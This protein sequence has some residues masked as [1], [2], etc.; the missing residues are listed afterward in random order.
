MTL[1][2][3]PVLSQKNVEKI[4]GLIADNNIDAIVEYG[5]GNSTIYFLNKYKDKHIKFISV[6]NTKPWFYKNIKPSVPDLRAGTY[7]SRVS[8]GSHVITQNSMPHTMS[9]IHRLRG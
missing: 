8:I 1:P 9:P 6:E 3:V 2:H 4:E 7:P 5:S